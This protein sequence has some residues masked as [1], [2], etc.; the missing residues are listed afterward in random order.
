MQA[1]QHLID[2]VGAGRATESDN[3][4][5]KQRCRDIT[6]QKQV[7][8]QIRELI[9]TRSTQKVERGNRLQRALLEARI[10]LITSASEDAPV[11]R[12]TGTYLNSGETNRSGGI[13]NTN[14]AS[15][16]QGRD[17]AGGTGLRAMW[18]QDSPARDSSPS[19]GS[20]PGYQPPNSPAGSPPVSPFENTQSR[21]PQIGA[22]RHRCCRFLRRC[23]C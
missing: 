11:D 3:N 9:N 2:C 7:S 4:N 15:D 18:E 14:A 1:A 10:E 6:F 17:D 23:C 22:D 16:Q 19:P 5:F 12:Y 20:P 8:R 21:S 13:E